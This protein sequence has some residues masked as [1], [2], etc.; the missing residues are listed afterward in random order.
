MPSRSPGIA[1]VGL[2]GAGGIAEYHVKGYLAH[3]DRI[4]ISAVADVNPESL[5][6]YAA[7]LG[8]TGY[9]DFRDLLANPAIDAV[10]ICLPHHLHRDAIVAAAEAGKHILCEKPLCLSPDEAEDVRRAV[11]AHG[12]TLMCAHNQ[13]YLP[14]VIQARRWLDADLLGTLYEVHVTDCFVNDFEPSTMGWRANSRFTGGGELIDTGY[15]PSY[16]ALH[17]AAARPA[18]V[19]AVTNQHRLT[20]MDGEDS[21]HVLVHF[22]SGVTGH[23]Q[24]SWAYALPPGAPRFTVTGE[25]GSIWSTGDDAHFALRDGAHDTVTFPPSEFEDTFISEIGAFADILRSDA[26]P[27]HSET[28]GIA[29]LEVILAAYESARTGSFVTLT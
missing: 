1:Q 18:A 26:A 14:S 27:I 21:A 28:D 25:R 16:L 6:R 7:E 19:A 4:R 15:H 23:V 9:A 5:A 10:D 29:V 3:A 22:E 2:I 8:A 24:T 12:V 11:G 13:L 20:F 17:L